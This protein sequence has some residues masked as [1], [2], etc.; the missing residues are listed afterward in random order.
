M[1]RA[2]WKNVGT[3]ATFAAILCAVG[4]PSA[5]VRAQGGTRALNVTQA[6]HQ[7]QKTG[8]PIFAVAG[9]SYCPACRKLLNTLNT[10]ESLRPFLTQ[11][12]PLKISTES[13]DYQRW[14][15][16]FPPKR[17][18]IPALYIV[19]AQGEQLYGAVGALPEQSLKKVMLDSLEKAGR[20]PSP[21]QWKKLG[22]SLE[23]ADQA[24]EENQTEK[25]LEILEPLLDGL[26]NFGSL[27]ALSEAGQKASG[28]IEAFAKRRRA[29]L[30]KSIQV[31]ASQDNLDSALK[32][33]QGERICG[34]F[35]SLQDE[36]KLAV[37]KSA[38]T[39]DQRKLLRQASELLQAE[40]LLGEEK[41]RRKAVRALERI[42]K[43][44]PQTEAA[45]RAEQQLIKLTTS[46]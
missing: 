46:K 45:A 14:K 9:A 40:A 8:R 23:E 6:I 11:F 28:E 44:Y 5:K 37:K 29:E 13:D 42:A 1:L 18:A 39:S 27:A 30:D 38:K 34:M 35:P 3:I 32:V 17:A 4:A 43:R 16:F 12:V 21:D 19:S 25:A 33:A 10:E 2:G 36:V 41:S 7:A 20:Y 26:A 31:F 15:K 22:Q 24:L